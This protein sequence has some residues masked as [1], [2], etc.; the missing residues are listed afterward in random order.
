ML[1][2]A[3]RATFVVLALAAGPALAQTA[4]PVD[5]AW[6]QKLYAPDLI[7]KHVRNAAGEDLAKIE[8]VA[9]DPANNRLVAVL[10]AGGFLGFGGKH[11]V[12]PLAELQQNDAEFLLPQ[13]SK[14]KLSARPD[15]DKA[16]YPPVT[17]FSQLGSVTK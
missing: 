7:G 4:A 17:R 12:V 10:Q 6:F 1:L 9:A 2:P 16:K 14:Q 11:A 5:G 8:E 15:Y 13:G 3:C